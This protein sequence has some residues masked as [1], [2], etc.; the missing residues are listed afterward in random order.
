MVPT[1]KQA[2]WSHRFR[3]VQAHSDK[4]AL[5]LT[6]DFP[7]E[8]TLA[9]IQMASEVL[10]SVEGERYIPKNVFFLREEVLIYVHPV[11]HAKIT[12]ST[13]NFPRHGYPLLL[14]GIEMVFWGLT[15]ALQTAFI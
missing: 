5:R 7:L 10:I 11:Y 8:W 2:A 12:V 15:E 3:P 1:P 13:K 6:P 14:A 4:T 9:N